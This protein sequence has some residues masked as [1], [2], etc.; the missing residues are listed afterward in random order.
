MKFSSRVYVLV[1][2]AVLSVTSL[3]QI[4]SY[5]GK[6]MGAS[7]AGK[8]PDISPDGR[9]VAY[10]SSAS[11][12]VPGDTNGAN[13]CFLYDRMLDT[14]VRVSVNS[15]GEEADG[16]SFR[17][18]VSDDGARVAF[19]STA[20]NLV[21]GD[22]NNQ[23]DVFVHDLMAG[24]T[25]RV[26]I[27]S[28]G[29]EVLGS[30][31][32]PRISGNGRYVV[33]DSNAQGLVAGDTNSSFDV[34]VRDLDESVTTRASV[35]SFGLQ[36]DSGSRNPSVSTDG[37]WVTFESDAITLVLND[38]NG[39]RDV[40]VRD[41]A[42]GQT[43][44]ASRSTSGVQGNGLS[45]LP[46]IAGDG[47]RVVFLSE[48]S[49][50]DA[51]EAVPDDLDVFVHTLSTGATERV[52]VDQDGNESSSWSNLPNISET[53]RYITFQS[54][55]TDLVDLADTNGQPDTFRRDMEAGVTTMV[56]LPTNGTVGFGGSYSD[57]TADGRFVVFDSD[58]LYL[59][60]TFVPWAMIGDALEGS[61]GLPSLVGNGTL[62][63]NTILSLT[64]SNALPSAPVSL[65]VG[66]TL[67]QAPFQGG[68]LVPQPAIV[69]GLTTDS[70]GG[71][72]FPA[73]WPSNVPEGAT[74]FLQCWVADPTAINGYASSNGLSLTQP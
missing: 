52:T 40:F 42:M 70:L 20:T 67:L 21:V 3:A 72:F 7:V 1:L 46:K 16:S 66:S 64:L 51:V 23:T 12:I 48:S 26:S 25:A 36:G 35:S 57:T 61:A 32:N 50:F 43:I 31:S 47:S 4:T 68:T 11:N 73:L 49:S 74:I 14:V 9:F 13:D 30:S 10:Y 28:N 59:R 60:D 38:T 5:V 58:S 71:L 29:A 24:T 17:P 2:I 18:T 63:G 41:R 34:F 22:T 53:G 65:V 56:S 39:E 62:E 45:F 54:Y 33:F 8:N 19:V 44:L 37:R 15:A 27:A 69:L 55:A 6:P